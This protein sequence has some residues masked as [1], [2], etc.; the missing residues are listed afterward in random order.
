[1]ARRDN[2]LFIGREYLTVEGSSIKHPALISLYAT[3]NLN[4]TTD[5]AINPV[6]I[7]IETDHLTGELKLFGYYDGE[8]YSYHTEN[9]L[10]VIYG[11]IKECS[12]TGKSMVY[13]NKL[14]PFLIYKQFLL[15]LSPERAKISMSRYGKIGGEWNRKEN[16]WSVKPV[17]ELKLGAVH[18]GIKNVIRSS[19]QF[20]MFN[21]TDPY[22]NTV[23]A[24]DVA[25]LY[26]SGLEA[27]M[28]QRRDKFPYYSKI[29]K[30]AHL[31]DWDRFNTNSLYRNDI[32]L[33]SNELDCRAAYDLAIEVQEMFKEAFGVYTRTLISTGSLARASIVATL[34]HKYKTLYKDDDKKVKASVLA[35]IQSIGF[36]NYYDRWAE[37]LLGKHLKNFYCLLTEAYSGGYIEVF[38]YGKVGNAL[39]ADIASAYPAIITQ[40]YDLRGAVIEYGTGEPPRVPN[41]YVFIRG[42]VDVPIDVDYNP[43]TVKH[44][45]PQLKSTNIR[46]V[47]DYKA[48]YTIEERDFLTSVGATFTNEEYYI[49]KTTGKLS[50]LAEIAQHFLDLRQE[51]KAKGSSA[52]YIAKIANNSLYGILFEAVDT[53]TE[54]LTGVYK[55]GYRAG[56]FFNPLYAAI[57]T[58]R[59]RVL[60]AKA[61]TSIKNNGGTP[62]LIMTDSIFW[63]GTE[64]Q[65]PKEY[66]RE[67]KTTGYFEKP[68]TVNDMV[69]LGIGRYSY[70]SKDGSKFTAKKRGLNVVEFVNSGST[71]Y[72]GFNWQEALDIV[73]KTGSNK[74]EVKVRKLLSVGMIADSNTYE[75]EDLGR[76]VEETTVVDVITGLNKRG[77]YGTIKDIKAITEGIVG[78]YSIIL[79]KG[80]NGDGE[81]V[82]QTLP[83]L[84]AELMKLDV[85]TAK[86]KDL[87]N[88]SKASA[89]YSKSKRDKIN[90][91]IK[92]IYN[93]LGKYGYNCK[94]KN[95][96][97]HWSIERIEKKLKEDGKL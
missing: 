17:V 66:W 30:E 13:W 39:T 63:K 82:D 18:F 86:G 21:E 49:V 78:T 69:C 65:L 92:L 88:R 25:Q 57:I 54:T 51:L 9:F 33:R 79:S 55:A 12:W 32:V 91:R 43:L 67:K 46:A 60:C 45:H 75:I 10:G 5:E 83:K 81:I 90:K 76:I 74:I 7:D 44:P 73:A 52:E 58:S 53:F 37:Q 62:I 70:S 3:V 50:P 94:E 34:N 71:E 61:A 38:N 48:S 19:I 35:D 31:V 85:K 29:S 6:S 36:I 1:M 41:S 16:K 93:R 77:Y 27:E 56:E 8:R 89:K 87:N 59:T 28:T 11:L 15:L 40:L 42:E 4:K 26:Q 68:T 64:D 97:S 2:E 14:D 47:G 80:M 96:M 23:W 22:L 24:Y 72:D 20:F 95:R 84:R